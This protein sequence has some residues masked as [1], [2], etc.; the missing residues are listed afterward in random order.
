M[1]STFK[2]LDLIEKF[3]KQIRE[4]RKEQY[5]HT[6]RKNSKTIQALETLDSKE[7]FWFQIKRLK[8]R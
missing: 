5:C 1:I 6:M 8:E 2:W 4:M 7:S 3:Q